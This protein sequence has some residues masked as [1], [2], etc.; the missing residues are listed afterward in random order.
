MRLVQS[1]LARGAGWL[2]ERLA[3]RE[4]LLVLVLPGI[5]LASFGLLTV[6]RADDDSAQPPGTVQAEAGA[7]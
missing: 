5:A 1:T 3:L 7:V 4:A 6:L 2:A